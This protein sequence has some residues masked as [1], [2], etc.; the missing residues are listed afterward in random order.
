MHIHLLGPP[1]LPEMETDVMM[2]G[3]LIICFA[4]ANGYYETIDHETLNNGIDFICMYNYKTKLSLLLHIRKKYNKSKLS[5]LLHLR[6]EYYQTW[7]F[8]KFK[9]SNW[10]CTCVSKFAISNYTCE[11]TFD[12]PYPKLGIL[13]IKRT[14][15]MLY[16]AREA[17]NR[18][19]KQ[20]KVSDW[21]NVVPYKNKKASKISSDLDPR[22]DASW[23]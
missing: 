9:G 7:T 21:H 14:A 18:M 6:K 19:I 11:V 2:K 8:F 3:Q 17:Y 10:H 4:E 15:R 22:I 16:M 1:N 13:L 5:L 20:E 23:L 12:H